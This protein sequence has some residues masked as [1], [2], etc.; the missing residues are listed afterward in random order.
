[1]SCFYHLVQMHLRLLKTTVCFGGND[2]GS[3]LTADI[4]GEEVALNII[5]AEAEITN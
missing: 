2:G 1:M 4:K 3:R 5:A